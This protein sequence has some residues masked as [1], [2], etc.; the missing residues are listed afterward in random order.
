MAGLYGYEPLDGVRVVDLS[1]ALAGPYCTMILG[2]LGADVIKVESPGR[3]DES[4]TWGPPFV[5]GESAYFLSVNRNKR[6]VVVNLKRPAGVEAF[7]GLCREADIVIE[8]FAPGT[9]DRLGVGYE[10]IRGVNAAVIY[11]SISG[12][13]AGAKF[14]GGYDLIAQGTSGVMSVTGDPHG[15]PTKVG[16]SIADVTAGMFTAHAVLAALFGRASGGRGCHIEVTL[17]D[18]LLALHTY[19]AGRMFASQEVPTREGNHHPTIAPYG[20][21]GAKDGP[22]NIAVGSDQQFQ[23]LCRVLV[24]DTIAQ[25]PRFSTNQLRVANRAELTLAV[26]ATLREKTVAAWVDL[27]SE[28]GIPCGPILDL[29]DAFSAEWA[30]ARGTVT[31][32][33]HGTAGEVRQV[34]PPWR[35]DSVNA[36][37]RMPPPALGQHTEEV[38]GG[39]LGMSQDEQAEAAGT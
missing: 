15:P 24:V 34:R 3:G 23:R 13:G 2:D 22:L 6:S 14:G 33:E 27:L 39:I 20:T 17:N 28:A 10:V 31:S 36:A 30:V 29:R 25:D 18:A 21:F 38:L 19:Q 37:V 16:V 12:Y 11:A 5:G 1:H 9:A 4:R 7:L 32:V 26:E 8:N 35:F